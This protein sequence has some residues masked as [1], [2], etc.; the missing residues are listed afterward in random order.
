MGRAPPKEPNTKRR[1]LSQGATK[2]S[3]MVVHFKIASARPLCRG[4]RRP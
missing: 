3:R 4:A 2:K 1:G